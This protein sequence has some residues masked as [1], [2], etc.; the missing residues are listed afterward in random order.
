MSNLLVENV[1]SL[2]QCTLINITFEMGF[3]FISFDAVCD[4]TSMYFQSL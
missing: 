3:S 1:P 2:I 4:V